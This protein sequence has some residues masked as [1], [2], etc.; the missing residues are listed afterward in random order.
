MLLFI[1]TVFKL[2]TMLFAI[3]SVSKQSWPPD[4]LESFDVSRNEKGLV[5]PWSAKDQAMEVWAPLHNPAVELRF[6]NNYTSLQP[7]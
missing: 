7:G 3:S 1:F 4:I 6:L 2:S 5:Q